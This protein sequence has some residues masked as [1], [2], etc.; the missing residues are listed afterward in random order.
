VTNILFGLLY[1]FNEERRVY[2]WADHVVFWGINLAVAG[3]TAVLLLDM[4]DL[5]KVVT[6]IL[7]LSILVGVVTHTI[8][9]RSEPIVPAME[10]TSAP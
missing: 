10:A 4:P 7:G 3:F 1:D 9:M 5:F 6:P 2:P 8:R